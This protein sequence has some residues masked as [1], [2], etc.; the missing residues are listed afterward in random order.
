MRFGMISRL[1]KRKCFASAVQ[2][3]PATGPLYG[4]YHE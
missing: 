2:F 1:M 3:K 4:Q